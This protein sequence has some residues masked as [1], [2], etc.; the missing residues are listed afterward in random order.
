MHEL[1]FF[2]VLTKKQV[3]PWVCEVLHTH[4]VYLAGLHRWE[5]ILFYFKTTAFITL[6]SMAG[7]VR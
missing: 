1:I 7:L 5:N 4:R 6:K 2:G 3:H